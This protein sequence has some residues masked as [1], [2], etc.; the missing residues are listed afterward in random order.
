MIFFISVKFLF[1]FQLICSVDP[2]S[3]K[4]TPYDDKIYNE[5]RRLFPDLKIDV[6]DEES[7]KSDASKIVRI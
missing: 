5:F 3:L 1:L 7:I 6:L 4:L 2:K